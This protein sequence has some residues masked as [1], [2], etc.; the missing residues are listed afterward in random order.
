MDVRHLRNAREAQ[1]G[2]L[3]L[4]DGGCLAGAMTGEYGTVLSPKLYYVIA[5]TLTG[6]GRKNIFELHQ[7]RILI[8]LPATEPPPAMFL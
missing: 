6:L 8:K 2:V 1:Q 5:K 3:P 7:S 4:E